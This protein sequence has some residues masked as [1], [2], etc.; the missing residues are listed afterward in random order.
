MTQDYT[1]DSVD[2][3][4]DLLMAVARKPNAGVTE[5][6]LKV[7]LTKSRAYRLL[8]TMEQR[9]IV[10]RTGESAYGLGHAMLIL[11]I[12]ASSQTDMI[13]LATPI[14][15]ELCQRVNETVQLRTI[16]GTEALCVAKAEPSRDLRVHANVGRRRPL[17]AGSPKCLLAFQSQKF[18][19][20]CVPDNPTPLTSSTPNSREAIL[21]E[22]K[23]IRRQG[24]C[25]SRGEVSDHQVSC[26]A[27]VFVIDNSV[28]AS[29]HVVAPAFRIRD[30]ELEHIIRLAT[31][32]A[33]RLSRAL[34]W[35]ETG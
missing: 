15:E 21:E 13:R 32:S 14:L 25:V 28:V 27:P 3:A 33:E 8:H 24:Y 19:D 34:G 35:S 2:K 6:A 17:Y 4:F 20:Q 18:I 5:L 7:G 10:K 30:S 1:V 26:A 22:L 23:K 12:T 16:D 9:R 29:V 31:S 11:G